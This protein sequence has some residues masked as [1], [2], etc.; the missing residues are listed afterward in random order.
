MRGGMG[1]FGPAIG[2]A[3]FGLGLGIL[4]WG[5]GMFSRGINNSRGNR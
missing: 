1:F 5:F 4:G 3:S 2:L